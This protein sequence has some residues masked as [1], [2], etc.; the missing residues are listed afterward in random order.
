MPAIDAP[1]VAARRH[2]LRAWIADH[3]GGEQKNF[4][5]HLPEAQRVNQGLLSGLLN[6]G[7]SFG[8]KQAANLEFLYGMPDGYLVKALDEVTPPQAAPLSQSQSV[9]LRFETLQA[10]TEYLEK[11]FGKRKQPFVP[12]QH[13]PLLTSVYDFLLSTPTANTVALNKKFGHMVEKRNERER[14]ARSTKQNDRGGHRGG[15]SKAKTTARRK[16]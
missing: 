3:F 15:A 1:I 5:A 12:S 16:K 11:E 10:A 4:L 2:R 14:A 8:E 9:T 13:I 7:K 6:G